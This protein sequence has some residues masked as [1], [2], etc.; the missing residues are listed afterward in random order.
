MEIIARAADAAANAVSP[1][2]VRSPDVPSGQPKVRKGD[3][4][5]V[6]ADHGNMTHLIFVRQRPSRCF[7]DHRE[8]ASAGRFIDA[9]DNAR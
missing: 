9:M 8:Q 4:R 3:L 6:T 1:V 7:G 5:R 2:Q